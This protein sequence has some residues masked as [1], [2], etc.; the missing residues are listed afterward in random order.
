MIVG[1][2]T[3]AFATQRCP[4]GT[5]PGNGRG[6]IYFG[7]SVLIA[8]LAAVAIGLL[9]KREEL[10]RSS[11]WAIAGVVCVAT[12]AVGVVMFFRGVMTCYPIT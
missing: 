8:I 12:L 10:S 11:T 9:A 7:V 3:V 6:A 4:S 2:P 1:S 5:A